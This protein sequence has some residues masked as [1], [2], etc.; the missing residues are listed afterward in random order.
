VIRQLLLPIV[1]GF[2]V[3][4]TVAAQPY[5]QPDRGSPGDEMIQGYL[6]REAERISAQ[7]ADDLKSREAWEA[8]RPQY[9]EEY[10]DMLGLSPRPERTPPH[11]T[12]TRTLDRGDYVVEMLH[13]Q[14]RP[15]LY[16]TGNLYRP[17]KVKE[18]E[19]LPA[20]FYVCGHSHRG[21]DGNKVAYQSHGI[22]FARHGYVCLAVDTLQLGEIAA[23]HHGTYNLKRWWWHSRGYT[24]A[25]VEAWNGVRGI[26][27]LVTRPDVD[28]ERIAVTGISGG[29]AATFWIA[30]ADERVKVAVP[31]S[32]MADLESYVGNRVINGHCDCMFLHN[33]HRWPWTRIAAL[34]APRPLLFVNSDQDAI[35]PMDANDRVIA[36]LERLYSLYG[37]GDR[38][39]ALVSVGGHAYRK[40]IRQGAYRFINAHLKGDAREVTDG[41]VDLVSEGSNPGPYPIPPEQLRV[42]PTDA[43]V[44]ADQLNKTIDQSFVPMAEVA[45]PKAGEFKEWRESLRAQ[46]RKRS[47]GYFPEAI[48]PA[49]KLG[50]ADGGWARMRSEE[51][52]EF[53]LR[54]ESRGGSGG[55]LLVVLNEDEGGTTPAWVKDV[56]AEGQAVVLCEPRGVGAT[57]WTRKDPPNYVERSH[58]LLGRTVD[59]GRVW[60]VIAAAKTVAKGDGGEEVPVSVAGRG[61]A[62]VIAAYAA[63]L[64]EQAVAGATLVKPPASHMADGA[65]QFLN[66]LRVCD[67]PDALGLIA[68]RPLTIVGSGR[69]TFAKTVTA[70]AAADAAGR[71]AFK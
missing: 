64:D 54:R 56:A 71:L 29:G 62:G 60:D 37:A 22:W 6:R 17:A 25:G 11:P 5:G 1:W 8:K 68:P 36:R 16:V 23:F 66:V 35:F 13:Y 3:A 12:V 40:D 59:T 21:R 4:A 26:D 27:Y 70:Y 20:V 38:V 47:F 15:G 50:E 63:V 7:F 33:G 34:V 53:R 58:A 28:P 41:E 14:S 9:V 52:I 65:P 46:L 32:G 31:V 45:A 19:R 48:P 51:G 42:F 69:D 49:T 43:D 30:A 61:A 57:R 24:P 18:G 67:V 55:T 2:T 10:F 39:D 44:P